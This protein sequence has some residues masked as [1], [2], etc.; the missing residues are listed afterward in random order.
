MNIKEVFNPES[1]EE[2]LELLN[3]YGD[4]AKIIAGGTDVIIE[5]KNEKINPDVLIDIFKIKDL[6]KIEEKDGMITIGAC[7]SFTQV[8]ESDL[9]KTNLIG[10]NK[11]CRLVGSPQIRNKGTIGGNIV[12]KAAAADSVPPL[13]CLDAILTIESLN[14]KREISLEE[15]YNTPLK[16]GELL[17]YIKF[18]KPNGDVSLSFAKLGLRKALAISRL[19]NSVMIEFDEDNKVKDVKVASGALGRTPVRERTVEKYLLG[20]DIND[21]VIE[22]ATEVL[23]S[24][25][26]E[27]LKGRSTFPYKSSAINTTLKEAIDNCMATREEL[28]K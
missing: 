26:E 24:S 11:A 16:N 19:T 15:Y 25:A 3:K 14:D 5:L 27:R 9:F 8:V 23:R 7:V 13:M 28:K 21:Q 18:N 17:T 4:K 2:V 12:N 1:I 6:K 10:F 22:Q 20:K